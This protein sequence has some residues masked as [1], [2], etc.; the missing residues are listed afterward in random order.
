MDWAVAGEVCAAHDSLHGPAMGPRPTLTLIGCLEGYAL[1]CWV[2][3]RQHSTSL[4]TPWMTIDAGS[5]LRVA[6]AR[7]AGA[8]V[9]DEAEGGCL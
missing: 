4:K 2:A 3:V 6:P 8:C 5:W 7:L 9:H 1:S